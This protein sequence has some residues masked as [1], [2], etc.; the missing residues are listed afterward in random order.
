M[1]LIEK[2]FIIRECSCAGKLDPYCA[3][4]FTY[5]YGCYFKKGNFLNQSAEAQTEMQRGE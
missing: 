1:T 2:L 3:D 4:P 5:S